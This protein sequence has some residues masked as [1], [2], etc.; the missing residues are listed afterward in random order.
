MT[1]WI[2][3]GY[4]LSKPNKTHVF[5]ENNGDIV[6]RCDTSV[7]VTEEDVCKISDDE[8]RGLL[9]KDETEFCGE[10]IRFMTHIAPM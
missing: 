9:E 4:P 2:M 1:D 7:T 5:I 8:L 6:Q 3:V 10:C